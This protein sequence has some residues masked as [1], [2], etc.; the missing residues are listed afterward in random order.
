[1][2]FSRQIPDG[3]PELNLK[4]LCSKSCSPK[5]TLFYYNF[6][7]FRQPQPETK[8]IKNKHGRCWLR[9]QI[10]RRLE[11][12]TETPSSHDRWPL[13]ENSY[14]FCRCLPLSL[15]T[16]TAAIAAALPLPLRVSETI[17]LRIVS[18]RQQV[19]PRA[20]VK[21][22]RAQ[23]NIN[24]HRLK[25]QLK[26]QLWMSAGCPVSLSTLD[27]D[28]RILSMR[29]CKTLLRPDPENKAMPI[30]VFSGDLSLH[31]SAKSLIAVNAKQL[32]FFCGS[33]SSSSH[34]ALPAA[35][36]RCWSAV[37]EAVGW[38]RE[39]FHY[40]RPHWD[41]K[42]NSAVLMR[43]VAC[44]SGTRSFTINPVQLPEWQFLFIEAQLLGV[45]IIISHHHH[46]HRNS[47]MQAKAPKPK[48]RR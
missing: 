23:Q 30:I 34:K 13:P 41:I 4:V 15:V 40:F 47:S 45:L 48:P 33:K 21:H 19:C 29:W 39:H 12:N 35:C 44:P 32:V 17:A 3:A 11:S 8:K 14:R 42:R 9:Q 25:L 1:L 16:V 36:I 37:D 18:I 38:F 26:T 5:F 22:R 20:P 46:H 7:W 6:F 10:Q 28:E 27:P 43:A 31:E 24:S 2:Y